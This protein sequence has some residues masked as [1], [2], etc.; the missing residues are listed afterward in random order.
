MKLE[1]GMYVRTKTNFVPSRIRKLDEIDCE[2]VHL[3]NEPK[4]QMWKKEDIVKASYNIIDLIEIGDYV[5]GCIVCEIRE[6]GEISING[7]KVKE[8]CFCLN[9]N[10]NFKLYNN[11]IETIVTKE[12]FE[13][14]I[15]KIEK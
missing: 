1:I 3:E 5:D 9:H 12:Q 15:Y 2:Y 11:E 7:E 4:Y 14:Q 6:K 13:S 8:K 10:Y